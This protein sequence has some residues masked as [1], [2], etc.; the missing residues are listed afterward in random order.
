MTHVQ[1]VSTCLWF[2]NEAEDA[3]RHYVTLLP[4]SRVTGISHYGKGAPMPEGTPLIVTFELA[5]APFMALNGG[6]HFSL[7]EAVS[8]VVQCDTQ[9]EIDHLWSS[10]LADGGRA[11]QCF[12]LKDR[13][14]LSWQIVPARLGAW[15]ESDDPVAAARVM[16]VVMS[17]V[18]ADIATLEAAYEGRS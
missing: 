12:W 10:L 6:P 17:S 2:N 5:G 14:G 8:L 9:A 7:S 3:A 11:Q 15:M 18:K 4:L 13:F 16:G 1:K